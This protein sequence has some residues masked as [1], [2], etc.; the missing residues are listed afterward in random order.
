MAEN[1]K[2][3]LEEWFKK[4]LKVSLIAD[5]KKNILC[6]Q[7]YVKFNDAEELKQFVNQ[8]TS[9]YSPLFRVEA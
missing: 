3:Y 8:F 7:W 6:I 9:Y 5:P 4:T 1:Y 2:Q